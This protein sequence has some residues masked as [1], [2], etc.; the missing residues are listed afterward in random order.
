MKLLPEWQLWFLDI[1]S[2][3]SVTIHFHPCNPAPL[4]QNT[5]SI[6]FCGIVFF[7][8]GTYGIQLSNLLFVFQFKA[9]SI[10]LKPL[11]N[12]GRLMSFTVY[13]S[14][15][16]VLYQMFLYLSFSRPTNF[17]SR[18]LL[19]SLYRAASHFRVILKKIS[20]TL[21]FLMMLQIMHHRC[22]P[23]AVFVI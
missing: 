17:K 20:R 4:P 21:F 11:R 1:L 16:E 14:N 15:V 18:F 3:K 19:I 6:L 5:Y 13:L 10:F 22:V 7:F 8:F 23:K 9:E 2:K 12:G